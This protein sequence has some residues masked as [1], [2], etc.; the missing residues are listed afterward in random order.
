MATYALRGQVTFNSAQRRDAMRA[1]LD[2]QATTRGFTQRTP[3]TNFDTPGRGF[4]FDYLS[5]DKDA[6]DQAQRELFTLFDTNAYDGFFSVEWV[7]DD[8]A[9]GPGVK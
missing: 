1:Q 9:P 8:N 3:T 6:V 4:R 7:S 5:T 2:S